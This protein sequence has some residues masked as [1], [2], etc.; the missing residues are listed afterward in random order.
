MSKEALEK[1]NSERAAVRAAMLQG[2]SQWGAQ[3]DKAWAN[4]DRGSGYL[5]QA[6]SQAF[7]EEAGKY[8]PLKEDPT[9][10]RPLV[11]DDPTLAADEARWG[12]LNLEPLN[13]SVKCEA[14]NGTG[15]MFGS[16]MCDECNGTGIV[17]VPKI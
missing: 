1:T 8:K 6:V 10:T 2:A 7:T 11:D 3:A 15:D 17:A 5:A 14:C 13:G 12:T 4:D 16:F 9:D